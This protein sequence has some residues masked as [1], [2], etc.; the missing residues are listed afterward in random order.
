MPFLSDI[1]IKAR[2]LIS[3]YTPDNIGLEKIYSELSWATIY[4]ITG[5]FALYIFS[6]SVSRILGASTWGIYSLCFV[7]VMLFAIFSCIG[8]DSALVRIIAEQKIQ[9]ENNMVKGIILK[10]Y[11]VVFLFG[12]TFSLLYFLLSPF[13]ANNI[14]NKPNFIPYMKLSSSSILALAIIFV[15]SKTLQGLKQIREYVFFDLFARHFFPLLIFLLLVSFWNDTIVVIVSFVIGSWL[16]AILS[17]RKVVLKGEFDIGNIDFSFPVKTILLLAIPL[18]LASSTQFIKGWIDTFVLGIF[19]SE[20]HIGVYAVV[21][22]LAGL[23]SLP[24]VVINS[25]LAPRFAESFAANNENSLRDLLV[26]STTFIS[27]LSLLAFLLVTIFS[28]EILSIFGSEFIIGTKALIILS[29]G[30]LINAISGPVGYFLQMT[31][32]HI[33]YRNITLITVIIGIILNF[34]FIPLLGMIGASISTLIVVSF[35]NFWCIYKIYRVYGFLS[36][37]IK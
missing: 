37:A 15:S 35:W 30:Q 24:L 21:V 10:A 25:S 7:M 5:M 19:M 4:K 29:V 8:I 13:I 26:R 3:K 16:V 1:F 22:K 33:F 27:I 12:T 36:I 6:L 23:V 28:K 14:L 18:F 11:L 9:S 34:A 31:G 20:L 32:H 17:I 2:N